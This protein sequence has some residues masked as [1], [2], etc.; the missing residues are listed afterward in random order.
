MG[1]CGSFSSD[2]YRAYSNGI[3]NPTNFMVMGPAMESRTAHT[4]RS[5]FMAD[6]PYEG[7]EDEDEDEEGESN[8]RMA[9]GQLRSMAEDIMLILGEM[10][11]D[12]HLESWVA[13]KITM[14]KQNLSAVA[15]YLRFND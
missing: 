8:A 2:A 5:T 10:T 1:T 6:E 3:Q 4:P 9:M 13:A 7:Y 12:D 14:S 15:D 11:P